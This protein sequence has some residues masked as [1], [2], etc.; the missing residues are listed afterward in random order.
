MERRRQELERP[1]GLLEE[2]SI[3][4]WYASIEA[5]ETGNPDTRYGET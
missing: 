4:L 2:R 5:Y 3:G 1:Y